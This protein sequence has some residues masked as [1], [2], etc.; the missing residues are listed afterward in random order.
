MPRVAASGRVASTRTTPGLPYLTYLM[1]SYPIFT[2]DYYAIDGIS[3]KVAAFIDWSDPSHLMA[4]SDPL[5]QVAVPAAHAD[6]GGK[7]CANFTG[8]QVYHSNR[9]LSTF[10]YIHNGTG[11]T[12]LSIHTPLAGNG[13]LIAT[14]TGSNNLGRGANINIYTTTADVLWGAGNGTQS[15]YVL[16]ATSITNGAATYLSMDYQENVTFEWQGWVKGTMSNSGT[17][18]NSPSALDGLGLLSLGG[19]VT[20]TGLAVMRWR[21]AAATLRWTAQQRAA[22]QQYIFEDTRIAA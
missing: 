13:V 22:W 10:R 12:L 18:T 9:P 21:G 17:T 19:G 7:L 16:G 11:M 14:R 20:D 6:F 1:Q 15:L 2:A 8:A 4:Q 3:S 5:K